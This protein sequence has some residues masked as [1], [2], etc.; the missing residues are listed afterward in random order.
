M[1]NRRKNQEASEGTWLNTYADL[2]TLLLCFFVLLFA[3]SKIDNEKFKQFILS[4]QSNKGMIIG[5]QGDTLPPIID[6]F[7]DPTPKITEESE[8]EKFEKM[9][10]ELQRFVSE[11]G[12]ESNVSVYKEQ[13]GILINFKD[14]VLFDK[15]SA[16]LRE[17]AVNILTELSTILHSFDRMVKVEGH[18][19]NDPINNALYPS[20]WELSTARAVGVVK[21]FIEGVPYDRQIPPHLLQAAGYGEYHPLVEN[22]SEENKAKNRRI[23]IAIIKNKI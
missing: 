7:S 6:D 4:F 2:V 21:F 12:L 8:D 14:S 5:N 1:R 9:Y 17:D 22:N 11:N 13:D 3:M 23:E 18:T 16:V 10:N 19:D 20:N 15:A